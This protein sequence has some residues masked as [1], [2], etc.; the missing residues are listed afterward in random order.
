MKTLEIFSL[1]S[2]RKLI[3]DDWVLDSGTTNHICSKREF[4]ETFQELKECTFSLP[5]ES[6]Y[7]V[8]GL[9]TVKVKNV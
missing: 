6:K 7:D 5:D 3:Q 1:S 4:F 9:G 8:M 2:G